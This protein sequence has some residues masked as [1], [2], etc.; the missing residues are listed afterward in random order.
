VETFNFISFLESTVSIKKHA[1]KI[2]SQ[3]SWN[4]ESPWS[5]CS[6]LPDIFCLPSLSWLLWVSTL[7]SQTWLSCLYRFKSLI[8][9]WVLHA[10]LS[11][12]G[13]GYLAPKEKSVMVTCSTLADPG[14]PSLQTSCELCKTIHLHLLLMGSGEQE[15]LHYTDN[16]MSMD[17]F[18]DLCEE[19]N[20]YLPFRE[21]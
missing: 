21:I 2:L 6:R 3:C 7:T 13:T 11:S 16:I 12:S 5:S 20:T 8:A 9:S 10:Y 4:V 14:S 17:S 1:S 15:A 18:W 19:G